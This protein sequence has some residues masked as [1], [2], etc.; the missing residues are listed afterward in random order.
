M[1]QGSEVP[2]AVQ[3]RRRSE[4]RPRHQ[5]TGAPARSCE[6]AGRHVRGP[7]G[8]VVEPYRMQQRHL[9]R[10]PVMSVGA[11]TVE[12]A[13]PWIGVDGTPR[14]AREADPPSGRPAAGVRDTGEQG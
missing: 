4:R 14:L 6:M 1:R 11:A 8:Q 5:A 13:D 2:G 3:S 12:A 9:L 10:A 7:Y